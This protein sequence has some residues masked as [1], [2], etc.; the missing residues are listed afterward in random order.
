MNK[1]EILKTLSDNDIQGQ[2]EDDLLLVPPGL[3][4]SV[5]EVLTEAGFRYFPAV[6]EQS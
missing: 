2:W 6:L 4:D 3:A 5:F 1:V